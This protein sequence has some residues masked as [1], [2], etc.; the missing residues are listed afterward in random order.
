MDGIKE[1]TSLPMPELVTVVSCRKVWKRIS[2]KLTVMSSSQLDRSRNW[3]ELSVYTCNDYDFRG[4]RPVVWIQTE[5]C[6]APRPAVGGRQCWQCQSCVISR[7]WCPFSLIC[8][9]WLLFFIFSV[10]V[11]FLIFF[12]NY[13]VIQFTFGLTPESIVDSTFFCDTDLLCLPFESETNLMCL[14]FQNDQNTQE[15]KRMLFNWTKQD[16]TG[17]FSRKSSFS[18]YVQQKNI[19]TNNSTSFLSVGYWRLA[20]GKGHETESVN[21]PLCQ[22]LMKFIMVINLVC[23]KTS[24]EMTTFKVFPGGG[25]E[26]E[27]YQFKLLT[28]YVWTV[29]FWVVLYCEIEQ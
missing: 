24:A 18:S 10:C 13:R 26:G 25:S 29:Q 23:V 14:L 12:F 20:E 28:C 22:F 16:K 15:I 4:W 8:A 17:K 6:D 2:A 21:P 7:H 19:K 5:Q 27:F 3:T 9:G 1:W 11:F